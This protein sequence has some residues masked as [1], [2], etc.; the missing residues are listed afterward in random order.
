MLKE[1]L[2]LLLKN[3]MISN[4]IH[5]YIALFLQ[6]I[7]VSSNFISLLD[8]YPPGP[9]NILTHRSSTP[10]IIAMIHFRLVCGY[11]ESFYA[12]LRDPILLEV[13]PSCLITFLLIREQVFGPIIIF[14]FLCFFAVSL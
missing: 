12:L 11:L 8:S 14:L 3:D 7:V 4:F 13:V 5:P 10:S 9:S 6:E 1:I 2:S